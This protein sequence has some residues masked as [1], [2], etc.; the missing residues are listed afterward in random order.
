MIQ[1]VDLLNNPIN[2]GD[3]VLRAKS[4]YLTKTKVVKITDCGVYLERFPKP[5]YRRLY[6]KPIDSSTV[7]TCELIKINL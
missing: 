3:E 7:Q 6:F 2:A 4:S 5:L 1:L